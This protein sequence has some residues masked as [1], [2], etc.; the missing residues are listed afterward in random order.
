MAHV[1]N[2]IL[3][4]IV[5]PRVIQTTTVCR[6]DIPFSGGG[7]RGGLH[8]GKVEQNKKTALESVGNVLLQCINKNRVWVGTN[9]FEKY[10][11]KCMGKYPKIRPKI[12]SSFSKGRVRNIR[13]ASI[14][15]NPCRRDE[16]NRSVRNHSG[17]GTTYKW[18]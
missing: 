1:I 8:F 3:G 13:E 18:Q 10:D 11:F 12:Q 6:A 17:A 7:S 15:Y 9:R 2:N 4:A 5:T 14:R 16:M